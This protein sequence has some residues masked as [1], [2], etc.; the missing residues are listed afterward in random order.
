VKQ[1]PYRKLERLVRGF[2]NHRRIEILQLLKAKPELSVAEITDALKINFKTAAAHI[3]KLAI[4]GLVL[5]RSDGKGIR[6]ALTVRAR[7][8]L[9]FLRTLV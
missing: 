8:V 9:T 7:Q 6:H 1:L 2:S 4:A 5:K 3:Q